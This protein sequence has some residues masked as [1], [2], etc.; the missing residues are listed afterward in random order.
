MGQKLKLEEEIVSNLDD[1]LTHN[2]VI[3]NLNKLLSDIRNSNQEQELSMIQTENTYG[4]NIHEIEKLNS[5]VDNEKS[6]LQE[7]DNDNMKRDQK[8][9]RMQAEI[10]KCDT[11]LEQKQRK[12]ATLNKKIEE[13]IKNLI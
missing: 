2:K 5:Q 9:Q 7:I 8:I 6:D 11:F 12:I 4:K 1:K 13:V 10:E 3:R